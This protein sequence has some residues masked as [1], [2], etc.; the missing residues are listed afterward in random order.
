MSLS[1]RR[2]WAVRAVALGVLL[3]AECTPTMDPVPSQR[4]ASLVHSCAWAASSYCQEYDDRSSTVGVD[5]ALAESACLKSRGQFEGSERQ[6]L[7]AATGHFSDGPC[8]RVASGTSRAVAR[9]VL[10]EEGASL[11]GIPRKG[12]PYVVIRNYYNGYDGTDFDMLTGA[13]T[14]PPEWYA[15]QSKCRG[16]QG[17]WQA[18][19]FVDFDWAVAPKILTVDGTC[20]PDTLDPKGG[21]WDYTITTSGLTTGDNG[22]LQIYLD[23]RNAPSED[24]PLSFDG[25][26]LAVH[27]D[28]ASMDPSLRTAFSCALAPRLVWVVSIFRKGATHAA[29]CGSWS[30]NATAPNV[31]DPRCESFN[32]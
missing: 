5:V 2:Y 15:L 4:V 1:S 29:D 21:A 13:G 23:N 32:K 19:P 6:A 16:E 14:P 10:A 22:M 24:H 25:K 17:I 28:A 18:P 8:N 20:K 11:Q 9:C 3:V 30:G 7:G 31:I 26:T 27:L 12:Q